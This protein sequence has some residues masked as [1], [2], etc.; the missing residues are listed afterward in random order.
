MAEALQVANV[1]RSL[2]MLETLATVPGGLS[3]GAL[4]G[5]LGMPKSATHRL[6]QTLA[7]R[8]YVYQ[9]ARSQDYCLSLKLAL[10]GFRFLDARRL[11]QLLQDVLDRLAQAC[12]EY[13]RIAVVEGESLSWIARAQ[14]APP[15]LRYDPPMGGEVVLHATATGK[16]WLATLRDADALRIVAARGFE[17]PPGFGGRAVKTPAALAR[18][19]AQTRRRGYAVAVEEGEP[20]IV[21]LAKAFREGDAPDAPAA[22]TVSIAGPITRLS[23]ER[24]AALAPLLDQ[25]VA[26]ISALWPLHPH[27]A[28]A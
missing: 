10:L 27:E 22:G 5:R 9:D 25:A 28:A 20:G 4:A 24:V 1:D 26:E 3:L 6:L 8:G 18:H 14:G 12:G 21:A 11:P 17:T 19:L 16:A 2:R 15:G 13:C 7:A 23:T